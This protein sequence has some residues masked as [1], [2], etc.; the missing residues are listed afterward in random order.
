MKFNSSIGVRETRKLMELFI[1]FFHIK[2]FWPALCRLFLFAQISTKAVS[3]QDGL[4]DAYIDFSRIKIVIKKTEG[5]GGSE[6]I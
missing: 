3:S 4:Q 5:V 6:S 2:I 1:M